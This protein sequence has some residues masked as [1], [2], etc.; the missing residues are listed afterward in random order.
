[1]P[2]ANSGAVS[3]TD[4]QTEFGGSN[5]IAIDE[6]YAGGANVPAGTSGTNG[7]VPSSGQIGV[8]S[9]VGTTKTVAGQQAY[10]AA[11]DYT[12]VAPAGVTSVSVVAIG[13]GGGGGGMDYYGGGGGGLGYKNNYTVTPGVGYAVK[14][15]YGGP[16]NLNG[17]GNVGEDSYFVSGSVVKGVAGTGTSNAC[18]GG[19][20]GDGGG[21]GARPAGANPSNAYGGGG[22]GG[23]AGGSGPGCIGTGGRGGGGGAYGSGAAGNSGGAAGGGGYFACAPFGQTGE[24]HEF[25]GAGGGGGVGILGQGSVGAGGGPGGVGGG[26]TSCVDGS[27]GGSGGSGGANGGR[28]S[29]YNSTVTG[30]AGGAYGGGGGMG[31]GYKVGGIICCYGPVFYYPNTQRRNTGGTGGVGAVRIIWPG[32]ARSFPSTRTANE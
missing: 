18:A 20:V 28:G 5:P 8:N 1:M 2:I 9:F 25:P 10:T 3:F 27:Y 21:R 4:I 12:W 31:G 14:V 30:G 23:Y 7:A 29:G 17:F 19:F 13:G 22:A 26:G 16:G 11:G 32:T 6:Y 24:V 15:G